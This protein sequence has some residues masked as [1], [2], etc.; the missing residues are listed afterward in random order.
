MYSYFAFTNLTKKTM[1]K[2]VIL[3]LILVVVLIVASVVEQ[4]ELRIESEWKELA[5]KE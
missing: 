4:Q 5:I 1:K 3:F 2:C